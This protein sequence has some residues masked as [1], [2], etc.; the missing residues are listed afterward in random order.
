MMT[1]EERAESLAAAAK[2]DV[3]SHGAHTRVEASDLGVR[4]FVVATTFDGAKA[5]KKALVDAA[6]ANGFR[7]SHATVNGGKRFW[8]EGLYSVSGC[9]AEKTRDLFIGGV[10]VLG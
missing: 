6:L 1:N 4:V 5:A 10:S 8:C 3:E 7:V 9:K 2:T